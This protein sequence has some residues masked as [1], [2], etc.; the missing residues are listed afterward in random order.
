MGAGSTFE[1]NFHLGDRRIVVERAIRQYG[2]VRARVG[3]RGPCTAVL[4]RCGYGYFRGGETHGPSFGPGDYRRADAFFHNRINLCLAGLE[5]LF[6]GSIGDREEKI[7]DDRNVQDGFVVVPKL[8]YERFA[9]FVVICRGE[10]RVAH[11]G[12]R[13][14]LHLVVPGIEHVHRPAA[15]VDRPIPLGIDTIDGGHAVESDGLH[16][17]T[18]TKN[19]SETRSVPVIDRPI[20][21]GVDG[22]DRCD[23]LA[24][25][26][27]LQRDGPAVAHQQFV[28]VGRLGHGI[29]GRR[30]CKELQ[31]LDVSVKNI[32]LLFE[33]R[34]PRFEIVDIGPKPVDVRTRRQSRGE[35]DR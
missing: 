4:H 35:Q 27:V 1:R 13:R 21:L 22:K 12:L 30:A 6:P 32:H 23:P 20:P 16:L 24:V 28:T 18:V 19:G 5:Q 29:D 17:F 25:S 3:D 14:R 8:H 33:R 15:A 10:K 9:G 26:P 2:H 7:I 31:G 34:H 11:A